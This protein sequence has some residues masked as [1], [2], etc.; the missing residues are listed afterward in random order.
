V[1]DKL[2]K[3]IEEQLNGLQQVVNSLSVEGELAVAG[4]LLSARQTIMVLNHLLTEATKPTEN[5]PG[6]PKE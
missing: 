5:P 2:K 6:S 1:N 4:V 3:S